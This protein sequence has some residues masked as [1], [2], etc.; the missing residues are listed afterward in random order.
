[1]PEVW[2]FKNGR[3]AIHR[4]ERDRYLLQGHSQFFPGVDLQ[5]IVTQCLQSSTEQGMGIA[6]REL[7]K[8]SGEV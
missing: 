6:L 7:R 3:L 5:A 8:Q 1:V 2:L 4:F